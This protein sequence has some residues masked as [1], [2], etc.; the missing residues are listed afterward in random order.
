[1]EL[2]T[3]NLVSK[4]VDDTRCVMIRDDKYDAS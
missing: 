2:N 1:M 4:L 3:F